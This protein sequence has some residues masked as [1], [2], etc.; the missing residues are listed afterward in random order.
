M[1]FIAL[2]MVCKLWFDLFAVDAGDTPPDDLVVKTL[3]N[4]RGRII[5]YCSNKNT[6]CNLENLFKYEKHNLHNSFWHP[7]I[8]L[9][10][11]WKIIFRIHSN[12]GKHFTCYS[13]MWSENFSAVREIFFFQKGDLHNSFGR[14][15]HMCW[16][17]SVATIGVRHRRT[18]HHAAPVPT[19]PFIVTKQ[20]M[21]KLS[22]CCAG[23]LRPLL[24]R[25]I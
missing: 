17:G 2:L 7:K 6:I 23:G 8:S 4:C 14:S 19:T 16:V 9:N 11:M 12:F 24:W 13:K 10:I 25:V 5:T 18:S 21:F 22:S 20:R 1:S 15:V 3:I